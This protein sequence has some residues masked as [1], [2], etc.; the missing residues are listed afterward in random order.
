MPVEYPVS[1]GNGLFR[2]RW[3]SLLEVDYF[4]Q[5]PAF[6]QPAGFRITEPAVPAVADVAVNPVATGCR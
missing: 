1:N 5:R 6:N 4:G 3:Q 2:I